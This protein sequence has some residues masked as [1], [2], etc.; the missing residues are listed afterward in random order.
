[1]IKIGH[2]GDR[3]TAS[4]SL[5]I[6]GSMSGNGRFQRDKFKVRARESDALAS[7][8]ATK[9]S[10]GRVGFE[11]A[12]TIGHAGVV[13]HRAWPSDQKTLNFVARLPREK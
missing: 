6:A 4:T 1:L 7:V 8:N 13:F 12:R 10:A 9:I 11:P 5:L 2:A 3:L